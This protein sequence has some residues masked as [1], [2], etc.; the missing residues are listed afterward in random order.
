ME[1]M[2]YVDVVTEIVKKNMSALL[3]QLLNTGLTPLGLRKTLTLIEQEASQAGYV[4]D[5]IK[6]QERENVL[7]EADEAS[8]NAK[9]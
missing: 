9:G 3:T 1:Y 4:L 8:D 6:Q 5:F 7:S 2:G